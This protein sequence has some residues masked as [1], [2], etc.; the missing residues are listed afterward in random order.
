MHS[1]FHRVRITESLLASAR[2]ARATLGCGT[3]GAAYAAALPVL[4]DF[5][6]MP[7]LATHVTGSSSPTDFFRNNWDVDG[8]YTEHNLRII[9]LAELLL[10]LQVV[11][12]FRDVLNR[13]IADEPEA[14][15][16]EFE[17][18]RLLSFSGIRFAFRLPVGKSGSDYDLNIFFENHP[19]AG[20]T[21]CKIDTTD[22]TP[23]KLLRVLK[24]SAR[25]QMPKDM[26]GI[27]FIKIPNSWIKHPNPNELQHAVVNPL[28]ERYKRIVAV[29]FYCNLADDLITHVCPVTLMNCHLNQDHRFDKAVRWDN[30]FKQLSGVP[31]W[32]LDIGRIAADGHGVTIRD[33][34]GERFI[35]SPS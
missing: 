19:I 6:G 14:I 17:T 1:T 25:K 2:Q 12:G 9:Q 8:N 23:D 34:L 32:W 16:A 30:L 20:E 10:N 3:L 31:N 13:L 28:F 24:R 27:F 11:P 18:A 29:Y 33:Q 4:I 22:S 7:W 26:A 35:T 5:L 15:I 21:K